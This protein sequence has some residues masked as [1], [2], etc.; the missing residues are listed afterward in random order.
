MT[1]SGWGGKGTVVIKSRNKDWGGLPSYFGRN[2]LGIQSQS[3]FL[4]Q[5]LTDLVPGQYYAIKFA[6]ANR[7]GTVILT[8]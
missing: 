3:S 4:Q 1:P 6:A 8:P 7:P 2:Y 5:T